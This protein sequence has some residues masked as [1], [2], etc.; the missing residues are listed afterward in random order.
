[1]ETCP[2]ISEEL[3]RNLQAA[4]QRVTTIKPAKKRNSVTKDDSR[5]AILK[6][7]ESGIANL[8]RW[9]K[10]AAIESPEGPQRIRGLAGSGKTVVLALKAAY[11]H[12]QHPDW[13][14][15]LTFHSRALYQQIT[16]LVTRFTFEHTNDTPDQSRLRI[17]HS[18]GSSA[19]AGVYSLIASA[20]G[21]PARDWSYARGKYGMDGAFAG[22]CRELL[23]VARSHD[24]QPIFDAVL[25]DEAQD[26]PPEFFQL[27]Y[28]LTRDPKRI[29][30]GYDELQKLS[31]A[32]MPTTEELFGTGTR[33]E[34]LI[35]L[36][37]TDGEPR[38]DIVLP[39]CYRNTP[40]ALA[41]AHALGIGVYRQEGLLQ[42]P[43]EPTLW[44]DVGYNVARGSLS[45]G[46]PV[47]L[48]RSVA[49]YPSYFPELLT[50]QDSVMVRS[51]STREE[52]DA[53]IAREIDR[54]LAED[55]LEP[56][57]IL[58]VLPD[59]Y[60]AKSRAPHL[61][62]HL[63]HRDIQS[64]LVG[65]NS[66]VDEVFQ[67]DSVAIAH[68][69]RAKGNEAPVVYAVDS[70][71]AAAQFNAV[72]RRNS[73]FTAITR[74]R[75]WVRITGWGEQMDPIRHEVDAV[76]SNSFKLEFAIPTSSEL[77]KLRHLHRDRPEGVEESLRKATEGLSVFLEA[78]ERGEL[79]LLDL[80][81]ALRTKLILSLKLNFPDDDR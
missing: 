21:K 9:Q 75:A 63:S 25:I 24:V 3:E 50:A 34:S 10:A 47:T 22:V 43:D 2:S 80:P 60:T 74:S 37:S 33:G 52:H 17:I 18:W 39:I 31:E 49:S 38:R 15:A 6:E 65:V 13:H 44:Q 30:W 7:I 79:D 55:E 69:Y 62:R 46:S 76:F 23:D 51:F 16:D 20:L 27:V 11:W 19:R 12:S 32:A 40:W 70:Q 48:E 28:L 56:D 68:I 73:L 59:S 45:P 78:Y 5:G 72:T 61:I 29:V 66:S 54:N 58:I 67:P 57:D 14:I 53:W 8:D 64:H 4:L 42:H 26:L 36:A 1:M 41:T 77:A 81:P 35:S 71:R